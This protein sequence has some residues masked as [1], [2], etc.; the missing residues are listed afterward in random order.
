MSGAQRRCQVG[1]ERARDPPRYAREDIAG[2]APGQDVRGAPHCERASGGEEV[3]A[4][5]VPRHRGIVNR[6][7]EGGVLVDWVGPPPSP[8]LL[9]RRLRSSPDSAARGLLRPRRRPRASRRPRTR[10][11]RPPHRRASPRWPIRGWLRRR[12]LRRLRCRRDLAASPRHS[13]EASRATHPR[14][15]TPRGRGR[16]RADES[17]TDDRAPSSDPGLC[18]DS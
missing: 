5:A 14:S 13:L 6:D 2:A 10:P 4:R 7:V 1:A 12:S 9:R 16:S 11:G 3:I 8:R 17:C 18:P 15:R